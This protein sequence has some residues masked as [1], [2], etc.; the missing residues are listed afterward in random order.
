[1]QQAS[2]IVRSQTKELPEFSRIKFIPKYWNYIRRSSWEN[3]E[4]TSIYTLDTK[5]TYSSLAAHS[6]FS[7]YSTTLIKS[8]DNN[9]KGSQGLCL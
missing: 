8:F 2:L 4:E 9:F 3:N 5:P 7:T 1:M 6:M